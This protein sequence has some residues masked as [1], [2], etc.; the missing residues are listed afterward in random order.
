M[1]TMTYRELI[2]AAKQIPPGNTRAANRWLLDLAAVLK[3][4]ELMPA[5]RAYL[6]RLRRVWQRRAS[7][8]DARWNEF[9][10]MPGAK[11]AKRP[12][13][14]PTLQQAE[15]VNM[16]HAVRE[17]LGRML[18]TPTPPPAPLN[19]TPSVPAATIPPAP[20]TPKTGLTSLLEK[21][22]RA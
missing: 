2:D 19:V 10:S 1:G 3:A 16:L 17:G 6:Y 7:G 4:G 22:G 11:P 20:E 5:E 14:A 15:P 9:G 12:E 13:V 18:D 8:E 21:Y